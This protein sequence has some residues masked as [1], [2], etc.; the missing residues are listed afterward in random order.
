MGSSGRLLWTV[1]WTFG[2]HRR[3]WSSWL[4][5]TSRPF[6][7]GTTNLFSMGSR[8]FSPAVKR[9]RREAD[10]SSPSSV[11]VNNT[12]SYTSAS[13]YVFLSW[14]FVKHRIPLHG[15]VLGQAQGICSMKLI[16]LEVGLCLKWEERFPSTILI[17]NMDIVLILIMTRLLFTWFMTG[18]IADTKGRIYS[19]LSTHH[20]WN[21]KFIIM[22]YVA[23]G[24]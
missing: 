14:C 5:S 11:E 2:F 10:H 9:P 15:V 12:W 8:G 13:P 6:L 16:M 24:L 18:F 19:R 3:R 20:I 1:Q 7:G 21:P 23:L 4:A 17:G 22:N